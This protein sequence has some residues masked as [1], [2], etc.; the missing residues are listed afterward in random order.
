MEL[1]AARELDHARI[2]HLVAV[3]QANASE[4]LSPERKGLHAQIRH[5]DAAEERCST[6]P[7]TQVRL[8]RGSCLL[9]GAGRAR[10]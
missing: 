2:R 6:T 7:G 5:L 3:A 8:R 9:A 1:R 10:R 4:L